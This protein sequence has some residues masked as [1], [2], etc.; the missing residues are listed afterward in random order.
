MMYFLYLH[1]FNSGPNSIKAQKLKA[2]LTTT[3]CD[4]HFD[5]PQLPIEPD[6]VIATSQQLLHAQRTTPYKFIIGT[7]LGGYYASYL[8]EHDNRLSG[9]ILINP[10]IAIEQLLTQLPSEQYHP[11]LN[12]HYRIT[13]EDEALI[14]QYKITEY[15]HPQRYL[16]LLQ[17]DDTTCDANAAQQALP[18]ASIWLGTGQGHTFNNI[19][20]TFNTIHTF[21]SARRQ[22]NDSPTK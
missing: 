15:R 5:N 19:D 2:W 16:L 18:D 7:S 13:P 17:D 8:M 20:L 6:Q 14:L 21:I 4:V 9:A 10:V 1:G 3:Y 11:Y 22:I 12:R